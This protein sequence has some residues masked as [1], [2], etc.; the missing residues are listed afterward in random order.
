MQAIVNVNPQWGIG[1]EN[2]LLVRISADMRRFRALTTGQT[3]IIGRK[4]LATF[5]GGNPL[6]HREN[7]VLTRDPAFWADSAVIC[8]DLHELK[9]ALVGRDPKSVFV[10]GGEQIYRLLLPYCETALVTLTETDAKADRFFPNLHLMD[11][12]ILTDAG[13]RQFENGI[14]FRFLTYTNTNVKPLT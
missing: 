12:W 2:R 11:N 4:T 14:P 13:E 9:T 5:P 6:K 1:N 10:C 7:I 3:V 8:H